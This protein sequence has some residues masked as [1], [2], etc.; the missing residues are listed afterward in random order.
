M[1]SKVLDFALLYLNVW[2]VFVLV[3]GF[4]YPMKGVFRGCNKKMFLKDAHIPHKDLLWI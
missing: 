4:F 2:S 1:I 3:L